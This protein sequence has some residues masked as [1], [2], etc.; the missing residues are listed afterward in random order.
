MQSKLVR[1]AA[2]LFPGLL[3]GAFGYGAVNVL[4]GGGGGLTGTGSQGFWQGAGGVAGTAETF[5]QFGS[6]LINSDD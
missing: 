6:S 4:Y 5:D 2:V 1:S 3:A